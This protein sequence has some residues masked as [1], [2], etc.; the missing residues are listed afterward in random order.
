MGIPTC[1]AL[2]FHVFH[3]FLCFFYVFSCF[4]MFSRIILFK[5][6]CKSYSYFNGRYRASLFIFF[7]VC[8]CIFMFVDLL[9]Y[10]LKTSFFT[11]EKTVF[12]LITLTKI[13]QKVDLL[14]L[15]TG[16]WHLYSKKDIIK[17]ITHI[18]IRPFRLKRSLKMATLA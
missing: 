5:T 7:H 8:A 3:V 4:F 6:L 10:C 2:E 13:N 14:L 18:E 12:S 17:H 16:F 9:V 15:K 11:S 1:F